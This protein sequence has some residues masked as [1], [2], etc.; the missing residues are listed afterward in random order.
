[1]GRLTVRAVVAY[2]LA[3]PATS[4][5]N[6]VVTDKFVPCGLVTYAH[7]MERAVAGDAFVLASAACELKRAI[8]FWRL[9]FRH[10]VLGKHF[11]P[12]GFGK[13]L[14]ATTN[15]SGIDHRH[16]LIAGPVEEGLAISIVNSS[17]LFADTGHVIR[18]II[19]FGCF[20]SVTTSAAKPRQ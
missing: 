2:L 16:Y 5:G 9:E 20:W 1:M 4:V 12:V 3:A 15:Y 18:P 19:N 17:I 8:D 11:R 13:G 10:R 14:I 7:V 6:L